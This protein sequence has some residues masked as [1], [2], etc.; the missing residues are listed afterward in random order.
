MEKGM[1]FCG[2]A[3]YASPGRPGGG[4]GFRWGRF[5]LSVGSSGGESV[6]FKT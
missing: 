6:G 4:G 2:K 1:G 3:P 5:G